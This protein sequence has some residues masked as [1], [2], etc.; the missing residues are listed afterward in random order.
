MTV[1]PSS[2]LVQWTPT[3]A[4]VGTHSIQ[5]RV[6]DGRGGTATQAYSLQ[7]ATLA[8]DVSPIITSAPPRVATVGELYELTVDVADPNDTQFTFQLL[9]GSSGMTIRPITGHLT[10]TPTVADV[11]TH[12]IQIEARDPG[13]NAA[14]QAYELT[15][16]RVNTAPELT[17]SPVIEAT[18]G[19][20][21]RYNADAVDADDTIQFGL[22]SLDGS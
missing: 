4:D 7:V 2:G 18:A 3:A 21:Y 19:E 13:G 22:T 14:L 9:V 20:A 16:R 17:S 8:N 10:W 15:V 11:G 6:T 5:L 1:D 12:S